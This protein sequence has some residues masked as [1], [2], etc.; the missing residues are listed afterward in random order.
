VTAVT[1]VSKPLDRDDA[2]HVQQEDGEGGALL[3][4]AEPNGPV[5]DDDLEGSEDPEFAHRPGR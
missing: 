5:V 4:P 1:G 3:R 2:V